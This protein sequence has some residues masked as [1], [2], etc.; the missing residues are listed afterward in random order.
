MEYIGIYIMAEMV[1]TKLCQNQVSQLEA[2]LLIKMWDKLIT[3]NQVV[4][5]NQKS[6]HV[7]CTMIC[8]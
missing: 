4:K 1:Q 8:T 7:R 6:V 5:F 2:S 3:S